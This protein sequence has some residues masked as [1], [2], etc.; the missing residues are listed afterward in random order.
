MSPCYQVKIVSSDRTK[1]NLKCFCGLLSWACHLFIGCDLHNINARHW[2]QNISHFVI[3]F[4]CTHFTEKIFHFHH[5]HRVAMMSF[6]FRLLLWIFKHCFGFLLSS[7]FLNCHSHLHYSGIAR[8]IFIFTWNNYIQCSD[9]VVNIHMWQ[10][11]K[12][13]QILWCKMMYADTCK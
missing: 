5:H 13:S 1:M 9:C 11:K 12:D 3:F 2:F 4:C 10:L 7:F 6:T 8:N